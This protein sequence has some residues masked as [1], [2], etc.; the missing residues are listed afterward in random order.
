MNMN[1]VRRGTDMHSGYDIGSL[2][3]VTAHEG[4]PMAHHYGVSNLED[5]THPSPNKPVF[6]PSNLS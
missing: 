5:E 3:I 2:N 6:Y 1:N 4:N